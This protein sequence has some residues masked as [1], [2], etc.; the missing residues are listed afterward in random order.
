MLQQTQVA[1]VIPYFERFVAAF[2]DVETLAASALEQVLERWSGLGYYSRA[3]NLHRCARSVVAEHR[4]RFPRD[5]ATM[6]SLPG[7]GRST[8]AAICAFAFGARAAILDGNV[9]RVIARHTG[10]DGYPGDRA[11]ES[12][13]WAAAQERLPDGDI[14]AYTQGMMDLGA[15]VCIRRRPL[16]ARCPVADDCSARLSN[17]TSAIPAPRPRK[18]LPERSTTMLLLHRA[19][20]DVLLQRRPAKGVWG[21]LWSLPELP[22]DIDAMGAVAHCAERFAAEVD[23]EP[24]LATIEHGFT[25]FRLSIVPQPCRVVRCD[26]RVLEA[27]FVWLPLADVTTA[28]LPAPV[29]RLLLAWGGRDSTRSGETLS[30]LPAE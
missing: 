13:L 23:V 12:R 4:G 27:G 9:K 8:A 17:R 10:I 25:H 3:R 16:C 6:A 24:R 1:A 11:V 15:T 29:K 19:R 21:G 28:A 20:A 7:I 30:L 2:P 14:E 22:A 26:E 5:V 18:P